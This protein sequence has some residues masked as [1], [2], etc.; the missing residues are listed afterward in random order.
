M[1]FVI[2]NYLWFAIGGIVI[3]MIITGFFAEKTNFGK[4]PLNSKKVKEVTEDTVVES[5][6][7][8]V[9]QVENMENKNDVL[10]VT[11]VPVEIPEGLDAPLEVTPNTEGKTLN[12]L[13]NVTIPD[14]D[15]NAPFGDPINAS[16][17]VPEPISDVPDSVEINDNLDVPELNKVSEISESPETDEDDVWKF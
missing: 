16:V 8:P 6:P 12:E 5:V 1:D 7:T 17:E 3:L 11:D 13:A 10:P 4:K 9:P 15:L 14:E 2:D